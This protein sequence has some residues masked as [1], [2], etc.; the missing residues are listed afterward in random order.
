M[1]AVMSTAPWFVEAFRAEYLDV[2]AHRD[3]ASAARE[4]KAT[5]SMLRF[6]PARGRLLD[7]AGGAGRHARA[8]QALRCDVVCFDL[9]DDLTRVSAEKRIQTVRGDMLQLPFHDWSFAGVACLF[10]SFG[11]FEEEQQHEQVLREIQRV[12]QPGGR[13]LLDLMDRDTVAF[14]LEPQSVDIVDGMT[15]EVERAMVQGGRRVEKSI[16]IMR[17]GNR[18]RAWTESVRLFTEEELA[19]LACRAGLVVERTVGDYNGQP[20]V[21]GETRRLVVL[22]K[23][24]L[25]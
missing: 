21:P 9:S 22:H 11:Y 4:A 1:V 2:Y 18:A 7:L 10:S 3:E 23:P 12:L 19:T 8:F 24:R 6:D 5:L 25:D 16:R 13:A 15:I 14:H 20:V 17:Q